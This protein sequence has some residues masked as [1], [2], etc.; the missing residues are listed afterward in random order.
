MRGWTSAPCIHRHKSSAAFNSPFG[1]HERMACSNS[2]T[3]SKSPQNLAVAC[4]KNSRADIT[5]PVRWWALRTAVQ[6]STE[7]LPLPFCKRPSHCSAPRMSPESASARMTFQKAPVNLV[8]P[9]SGTSN[10]RFSQSS[11]S[12]HSLAFAKAWMMS[13]YVC[14]S[15]SVWSRHKPSAILRKLPVS[16]PMRQALMSSWYMDPSAS[17]RLRINITT[18]AHCLTLPALANLFIKLPVST[19]VGLEAAWPSRMPTVVSETKTGLPP[20]GPGPLR[21]CLQ[22]VP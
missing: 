8:M 3:S 15:N 7:G 4:S 14:N 5:S 11:A 22:P 13:L 2:L 21:S 10:N 9:R 6:Q 17:P 12:A 16:P 18:E 20:R 1:R 19:S